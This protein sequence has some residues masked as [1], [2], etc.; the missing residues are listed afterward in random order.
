MR[1]RLGVVYFEQKEEYFIF[2]P[3]LLCNL[4]YLYR[5]RSILILS[6]NPLLSA[7]FPT[8]HPPSLLGFTLFLPWHTCISLCSHR[9]N[10][11]KCISPPSPLP[12]WFSSQ[13]IPASVCF[14]LL[15]DFQ[16][17]KRERDSTHRLAPQTPPTARAT[18]GESRRSFQISHRL[19]EPSTGA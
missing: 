2:P 4:F 7:L 6:P 3:F 16:L 18:P 10:T 1:L 15:I 5:F 12:C 9:L 17:L 8:H 13:E 11:K 14:S 19:A